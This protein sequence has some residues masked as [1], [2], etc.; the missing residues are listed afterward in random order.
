MNDRAAV[1][2]QSLRFHNKSVLLCN[3]AIQFNN[4]SL[5]AL[6]RHRSKHVVCISCIPAVKSYFVP[7]SFGAGVTVQTSVLF[8][9]QPSK[10]KYSRLVAPPEYSPPAKI[11]R[12]CFLNLA[13]WSVCLEW[14]CSGRKGRGTQRGEVMTLSARV[15]GSCETTA[16]R[17][18]ERPPCNSMLLLR[19]ILI[20]IA[21]GVPSLRLTRYLHH[22]GCSLTLLCLTRDWSL[23]LCSIED[24]ITGKI[25]SLKNITSVTLERYSSFS[26]MPF[27]FTL[28]FV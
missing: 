16:W 11:H 20:L 1:Q 26:S 5:P 22:A 13:H 25:F 12:F 14:K 24:G 9:P 17:S 28:S 23:W 27:F 21:A 6:R 19:E 7:P 15:F 2:T 10:T 3:A 18:P 4:N 8:A